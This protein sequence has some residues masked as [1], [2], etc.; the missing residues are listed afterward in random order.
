MANITQSEVDY[1]RWD[2]EYRKKYPLKTAGIIALLVG[3]YLFG[4][5]FLFGFFHKITRKWLGTDTLEKHFQQRLSEI[6][7]DSFQAAYLRNF[8]I[9]HYRKV[10]WVVTWSQLSV[11]TSMLTGTAVR[12]NAALA[13]FLVSNFAAGAYYNATLPPFMI[14]SLV[15]MASP[16]GHWLGFDKKLHERYPSSPFFK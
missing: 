13:L 9:P 8:A 3:R 11:C 7:P 2:K 4:S 6:D 12:P 14:Y 1:F 15:L 10:A 5:V 16:S